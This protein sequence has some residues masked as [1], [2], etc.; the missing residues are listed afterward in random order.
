M[1]GKILSNRYK[2]IS[3]LGHGGMA[4]VYLA[5]DLAEGQR[6]AIKILYPHL[7][8]DLVFLLRFNQEAKLVMG[9]S[10]SLSEM[11]MVRVLD[12]G[13]DRD[14]RYLVMEYVDGCDLRR[15]LEEQGSI[16]W[17]KAL[18][19][20]R[21]IA[22][23][24]Q[25]A[26]EHGIVHRDVK[27]ANVMLLPDGT[28]RILDFGIAR[29]KTSPT[30]THSG[31]VGSPYYVAP[32]QAMGRRVDIRADLYSLGVVMYEMLTG[33]RPFQSDTPAVV[34]RHHIATPPPHLEEICPDLPV[35]VAR[36]VRKAMAKRPEDRFQTPSEMALAIETILAGYDLGLDSWEVEPD[37][38]APLLEALYDQAQKAFTSQ[39]WREAVDLFGQILR[40]EPRYRDI[41]EQLADAGRQARFAALYEAAQLSIRAGY[42]DEALAELNEISRFDPD[43]RDIQVLQARA[44]QGRDIQHIGLRGSWLL[45]DEKCAATIEAFD[46]AFKP[47]RGTSQDAVPSAAGRDEQP[48]STRSSFPSFGVRFVRSQPLRHSRGYLI[49]GAFVTLILALFFMSQYFSQNR[50]PSLVVADFAT[51]TS[52]MNASLAGRMPAPMSTPSSLISIPTPPDQTPHPMMS[53]PQPT[54]P[55][56]SSSAT[57]SP[58]ST[59]TSAALLLS[60]V[61]SSQTPALTLTVTSTATH[62]PTHS[63]AP[64]LAGQIA[65]PRFDPR[66]GTYDVFVCDLDGSKCRRV[67]TEASQPD[68]LPDGTRLVVHS[69]KKDEKG[70]VLQSLSGQRIWRITERIEAARPSVD[71]QGN[72][73]VY[74]SRQEADR[75]PYL[76]YTRGTET[77]PL[78]REA[79]PVQ[80]QSPSWLPDGRI[81][82]SGCLG[83]DCGIIVTAAD[84][85]HPRQVVAG[86]TETNPEASPDGRQVAF[87]SRRDGNWEIYVTSLDGSS[88]RRLTQD[89]A[90]DGLPTWSPDGQYIAFVSDRE[91]QWAIWVMRPDGSGQRRL[92]GLGG[93]LDGAVRDAAP[94]EIH[95]WVEERISWSRLP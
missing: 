95:G 14:L 20:S 28:A 63:P 4:W 2:L 70:L 1:I 53:S 10:Q 82:Y 7:S 47:A 66:R 77:W 90:S 6:V 17:K 61:T 76:Y 69:W 59:S 29:T 9:L 65:F 15:V 67:A 37:A 85:S 80:G 43:Y 81:L 51:P 64:G 26:Y 24:L 57:P 93:P 54:V 44:R 42:W 73:Y 39:R 91:G 83:G 62:K 34:I 31:F 12:Y 68:L 40:I 86:T 22:L 84:G 71:A 32:E 60:T 19:I 27:P 94:H 13:S 92:F 50:Q 56:S 11:Q 55:V 45:D 48:I 75:L 5:E 33:D 79:S 49:L 78:L 38:L 41:T 16:S 46:L 52:T 8:E 25:Q 23:G 87:M 72:S 21:Q 3:E 35:A 88:P 30:L 58:L 18:D 74:H 89:P 36:L